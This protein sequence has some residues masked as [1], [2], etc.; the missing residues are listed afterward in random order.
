MTAFP[1]VPRLHRVPGIA[2]AEAGV[3]ILD[4]PDGI[5]LTMTPD[6]ASQTG[7]SLILAAQIAHRQA[8]D[9]TEIGGDGR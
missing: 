5:A 4:G 8:A 2:T 1:D 7:R 6:A 9:Q 3:V